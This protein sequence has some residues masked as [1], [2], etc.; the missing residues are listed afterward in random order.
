M[1]QKRC[2]LS[3]STGRTEHKPVAGEADTRP[4]IGATIV[5]FLS[6]GK[7]TFISQGISQTSVSACFN[8]GRPVLYTPGNNR[9]RNTGRGTAGSE[10]AILLSCQVDG[11]LKRRR[12]PTWF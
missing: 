2:R 11:Q 9:A 4:I 7:K 12:L 3:R 10:M 6:I 5:A 8:N 1:N